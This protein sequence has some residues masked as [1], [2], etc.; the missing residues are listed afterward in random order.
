MKKLFTFLLV[1]LF[2]TVSTFA[3]APEKMSYQA[4]VRN[5][6]G[7]LVSNQAVMVRISILRGSTSGSV[8]YTQDIPT[9]TNANG[10]ISI[11]F[12]GM[13][14]FDE[15]EWENYTFFIKTE[16]DPTSSTGINFSISGISQML[17]VPYALQ[18]QNLDGLSSEYGNFGIGIQEPQAMLDLYNDADKNAVKINFDNVVSDSS[19]LIVKYNGKSSGVQIINN[20]TDS[21]TNALRITDNNSNSKN[22]TIYALSHSKGA[23]LNGTNMNMGYAGVFQTMNASNDKATVLALNNGLSNAGYF[24]NNNALNELASLASRSYSKGNALYCLSNGE[25]SVAGF[26]VVSTNNINAAVT[27][28]NNGKGSGLV[29]DQHNSNAASGIHVNYTNG[30]SPAV[31][32]INNSNAAGNHVMRLFDHNS[33]NNWSSVHLESV[34]RGSA[35]Y[36]KNTNSIGKAAHFIGNV[37]IVGNLSISGN[38]S[39]GGGTFKIDHPLDPKNKFLVHSFV[40]SPEMI[41]IYSGN[42]IT[43]DKG[44]SVVVMPDYF[45][46]ANKDFRYQLTVIGSFAQSIIYQEINDNSFIVRT[47][48]PG[49]KV[50]WQV[51]AVRND[52][53]AQLNPIVAEQAKAEP[54]KGTYLH[55]EAYGEEM[56]E[57]D[58]HK[59]SVR[60]VKAAK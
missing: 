52:R 32:I 13:S 41:N 30:T 45:E 48:E 4:V 38:I 12:G 6:Q 15:I 56:T 18:S 35:L 36:V 5:S 11:V 50:S 7:H 14:G 9:T 28:N 20:S 16:I 44:F 3:Q 34:A 43:D 29:I 40:E 1:L 57:N 23:A 19:A 8:V 10:L 55:P 39:K 42:T 33:N 47:S 2:S 46:A 17:S 21:T 60:S 25:G 51:T 37:Q 54:E 31:E 49:I 22:S 53:Y 24:E 59:T 26:E 27:I 58:Q